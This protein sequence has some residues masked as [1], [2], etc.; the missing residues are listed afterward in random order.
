M[1]LKSVFPFDHVLA[2]QKLPRDFP[3]NEHRPP[4]LLH[5]MMKP[6]QLEVC[7]LADYRV[8]ELHRSRFDHPLRC[9]VSKCRQVV[10]QLDVGLGEGNSTTPIRLIL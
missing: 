5:F 2:C 7:S 10:S 6:T 3:L 1:K 4:E 8:Y 9:Q